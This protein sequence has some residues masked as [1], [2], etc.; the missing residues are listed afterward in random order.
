MP[1]SPVVIVF[2]AVERKTGNVA[3]GA[4]LFAEVLRRQ[5]VRGVFN[6]IELVTSG[7]L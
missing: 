3:D 4:N 6:D 2:V 7:D 1:P 5:R